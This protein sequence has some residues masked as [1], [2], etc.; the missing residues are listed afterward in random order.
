[1]CSYMTCFC[2]LDSNVAVHIRAIFPP[3]KSEDSS[4]IYNG[5]VVTHSPPTSEVGMW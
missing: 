4:C 1:M 2:V 3:E 5:A